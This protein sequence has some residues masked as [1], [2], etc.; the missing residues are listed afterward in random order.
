MTNT[1][2]NVA[3]IGSMWMGIDHNGFQITATIESLPVDGNDLRKVRITSKDYKNWNELN[4]IG[5]NW[6]RKATRIS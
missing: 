1:K 4:Y 6:F 5:K 2:K 3:P